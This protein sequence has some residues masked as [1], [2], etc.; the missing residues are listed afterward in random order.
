MG[1][2]RAGLYGLSGL[3]LSN[4]SL[5][6]N[7]L[8][9]HRGQHYMRPRRSSTAQ[10]AGGVGTGVMF[11]MRRFPGTGFG[12]AER[13]R[14]RGQEPSSPGTRDPRVYVTSPGGTTSS[15]KAKSRPGLRQRWGHHGTES[16][17]SP[18][19]SGEEH[20]ETT[21]L[22]GSGDRR[23]RTAAGGRSTDG[24]QSIIDIDRRSHARQS[25]MDIPRRDSHLLGAS[26]GA[27][28]Y[29]SV[30]FPPS[31][32][33]SPRMDPTLYLDGTNPL[34]DGLQRPEGVIIDIEGMGGARGIGA[35]G[36]Q[37]TAPT[38]PEGASLGRQPTLLR[39]EEDVCF[40]VDECGS[41]HSP[42]HSGAHHDPRTGRRIP[43]EFPDLSVLEEWSREE[44][45]QRSEGIR[46][47][48]TNEPV[49]VNGRLRPNIR[50]NLWHREEEDAPYRFTYFNDELPA[51]IHAHTISELLLP[52]QTFADLFRPEPRRCEDDHDGWE[53]E[54]MQPQLQLQLGS[55]L[56]PSGGGSPAHYEQE[57]VVGSRPTFWLDVLSPTDAEM[58]ILSKAFGIHPLTAEDIMMQEA[59]EKVELFRSYY[60]VSYKSFE[61]D[62]G[63]EDY[64][65]PVNI[66]VVVFREGV[67]SVSFMHLFPT[68]GDVL[69]RRD[70]FISPSPP[71]RQTSAAASA[72]SKTTLP[73][74]LTG[75]PTHSL[76]TSP[77]P[78]HP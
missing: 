32:P 52:G 50:T 2:I 29:G 20:G 54:E 58:K 76:T 4:T 6:S 42:T 46:A 73:S 44:K 10:A 43:R 47:K 12:D 11:G 55:P 5:D 41:I 60:L 48:K 65:D 53:D 1:G 27:M 57:A 49:Y 40:P 70:S 77:T 62:M 61:Q 75:F 14:D 33:T 17:E 39:A 37:A 74:L 16:D 45:E 66:Y 36:P 72:N 28:N 67:I 24:R 13:E 59:R 7:A 71:T 69:M 31:V 56:A 25:I 51:T 21:R 78:L 26:V 22:L 35:Q 68:K 9:D 63:S 23:S 3:N 8:L 19:D 64:L 34:A 30:N 38:P 15:G 18:Y